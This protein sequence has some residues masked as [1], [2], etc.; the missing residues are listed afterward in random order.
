[1]NNKTVSDAEFLRQKAKEMLRK[2]IIETGSELPDADI[3]K[4]IYELE[5]HKLDLE[6]QNEELRLAKVAEQDAAEKY[7]ELY[8]F[9][10]SGYFTLSKEGEIVELNLSGSQMLGKDCPKLKNSSFSFFI[11]D[12]TKPNFHNFLDCIFIGKSKETCEVT[13]S[14]NWE[15]PMYVHLTGI[16]NENGELCLVTM[17]DITERKRTE[18][19]IIHKNEQLLKLD[20]EKDKFFS[21]IAHD[22]RSPFSSFLELTKVLTE[23]ILI[24]PMSEILEI[25]VSM[26]N[27]ATN[28]FCLLENLLH[29]ARMQQGLIPIDPKIVQLHP[30]VEKSIAVGLD[31]AKNKGIE[32][33]YDIPDNMEVFADSNIL[34]SVI[35]NLVSNAVKFTHK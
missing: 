33:T 31:S 14:V 7:R 6:L 19:E 3:R 20:A 10:P 21:I 11:S 8:D 32:I 28:L 27:S 30:I 2:K 34:Q 25:A 5:V 9:A 16:A 26:R 12:D 17:V 18:T 4:F 13:L 24:L 15:L 1:M 23:V 29:W 22:L 35:R